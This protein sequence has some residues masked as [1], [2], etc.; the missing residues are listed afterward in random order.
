M[1]LLIRIERHLQATGT[2]PSRFGRDVLNDPRF[3]HDL[4]R[5]GRAP[6][7][8]TERRVDAY[9]ATQGMKP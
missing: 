7:P 8:R 3:V 4:R 2:T 5:F 6:R 9:L 1:T